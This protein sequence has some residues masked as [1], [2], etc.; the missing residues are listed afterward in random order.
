VD[1]ERDA[2]GDRTSKVVVVTLTAAEIG[3]FKKGITG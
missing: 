3:E 2:K 1:P